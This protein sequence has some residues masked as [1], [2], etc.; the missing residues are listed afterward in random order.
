MK[1]KG[2][3]KPWYKGWF[4]MELYKISAILVAFLIVVIILLK[5]ITRHNSELEV[6][7]FTRMTVSEAED[8][9]RRANL[10]L[11]V[12]DSVFL[13]RMGRGE[14]FRQNPVAGSNVKKN[15][16]VLLTI[17]SLQPKKVSMPSVT[18]YSLRQA[19][20][21]LVARQLRVGRLIY[22]SDMATNN[23]LAQRYNGSRVA[24][25]TLIE[26]ESEIDL[27]VGIS[28]ESERTFV[29]DVIALP[30]T[31][32]RDILIDNSLNI[33]KL[34]YDKSVQNYS[35]SISG[36]V[37]KQSPEPSQSISRALGSYVELTLS[38]DRSLIDSLKKREEKK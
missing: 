6:P 9:A 5:I 13:P 24:P 35:D 10:R 16:R 4:M 14:I 27:E 12:T 37:I 8:V 29:P 3:E 33:S 7:D 18:G 28:S 20:A 31:T 19:K 21:E 17:N 38:V 26:T 11:E 25:G 23:V 36:F 15:R 34:K 22:V 2:A 30:L 1:S 32:A